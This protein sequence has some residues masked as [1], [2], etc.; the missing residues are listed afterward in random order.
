[1]IE[2]YHPGM[3]P[4]VLELGR[5]MHAESDQR[6]RAW[7]DEKIAKLLQSPSIYCALYRNTPEYIGGI[8]GFVGE[9]FFGPDKVAKDLALF[10]RPTSRGSIAAKALIGAF[11]HWARERGATA[12]YLSQSTGVAIDRTVLMLS[13]LGYRTV[14]HVT[15]KGL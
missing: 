6:G 8:I 1:M 4:A 13:S 12:M 7:S 2:P 3:L 10:V 15:V 5:F 11:E 9:D 14:G